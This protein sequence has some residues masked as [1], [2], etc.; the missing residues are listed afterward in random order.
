MAYV[1]QHKQMNHLQTTVLDICEHL[2]DRQIVNWHNCVKLW[3]YGSVACVSSSTTGIE[4]H[5]LV[6]M[7]Y[8]CMRCSFSRTCYW[9]Q[10]VLFILQVVQVLY[11]FRLLT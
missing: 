4:H 1:A 2:R 11:C 8:S 5:P 7:S 6:C 10:T 9:W 3:C